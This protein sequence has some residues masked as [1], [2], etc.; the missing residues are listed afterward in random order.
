MAAW[1]GRHAAARWLVEFVGV[2]ADKDARPKRSSSRQARED[3]KPKKGSHDV[4]ICDLPGGK[5]FPLTGS[6]AETLARYWKG[7][8]QATSHATNG[9]IYPSSLS[10]LRA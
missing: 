6:D 7:V 1:E 5:Y 9:S 2:A 10:D 8:S 3:G 4:D